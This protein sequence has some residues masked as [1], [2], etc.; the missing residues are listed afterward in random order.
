MNK[1]NLSKVKEVTKKVEKMA[2]KVIVRTL[3]D[4][5]R[6]YLNARVSN[7][8][9]DYIA[10]LL[11]KMQE[12]IRTNKPDENTYDV[13]QLIF[14]NLVGYDTT[15]ADFVVLDVMSVNDFSAKRIAYTAA[16]QM[17]NAKSD[18]VLMATQRIQRDLTTVNPLLTSIVLTSIP[19]YLS[20]PLA[21]HI[22]HD[23]ISLMTS[24]K[25]H[26]RQK[27]IMTFYHICL[28][29]PDALKAGFV[30]L[31]GRLDDTDNSVVF[32]SLSVVGELCAHNPQ[33]FVS[34]IPKL[35][36]MLDGSNSNWISLRLV[37]IL[38][39]LCAAEPRLPKKLINP[40]TQILETTSS[41]TLLFETVRAIIEIPITNTVLLTYAAQ[42][43]QSFLE[44]Q[45]TNLRYL[46]LTLFIKL[47][48]IQPKLVAQHKELISQ[49]LDS[50]DEPTRLMALDLLT[51]L[52]NAK[53]ID[54]I[55]AKCYEHYSKDSTESFKNQLITR[56][57]EI[58]SKNDYG[59]VQDFDWYITVLLDFIEKGGFTCY[60]I[61]ADQFLDLAYR[62]PATR[63]R[64]VVEMAKFF[65][66]PDLKEAVPLLL[67]ASHIVGDYA[68]DSEQFS[69]ILQ[70]MVINMNERVQASC[71]QTAFKLYLKCESQEQ[72][73]AVEGMFEL[74][75]PLLETSKYA[76]VQDIANLTLNVVHILRDSQDEEG[77]DEL[78]AFM[79]PP[80]DN[81][82]E[83]IEEII[84]PAELDEP[85]EIFQTTKEDHIRFDD[86]DDP[87]LQGVIDTIDEKPK[88]KVRGEKKEKKKMHKQ[89]SATEKPVILKTHEKI[90]KR[91]SLSN[92]NSLSSG[93]KPSAISNALATIDLSETVAEVEAKANAPLQPTNTSL[94]A[95]KK[96][97]EAA[98]RE[99]IAE[100]SAKKHIVKKKKRTPK[101]DAAPSEVLPKNASGPPVTGPEGEY[102][103]QIVGDANT[104]SI[105]GA[106]F[107]VQDSEPNNMT[108]DMTIENCTI[109]P[110]QSIGIELK[111]D[112]DIQA[113]DVQPVN[114][115]LEGNSKVSHKIVV[116]IQ[117][118][119]K[120]HLLKL[121]FVPTSGGIEPLD[122]SFKI[123]PSYF[124]LPATA[125]QLEDALGNCA[126][127]V[128][129]QFSSTT[130]PKVL[131]QCL[132]NVL[133]GSILPSAEKRERIVFSKAT[134]G[135]RAVGILIADKAGPQLR[136]KSDDQTL[137]ETLLREV[138]QA[139]QK[140]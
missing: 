64:L 66:S 37:N 117:N 96:A 120:P 47:M 81:E 42:R 88:K 130:S 93:P 57:V 67:A 71:I 7:T 24:A 109:L 46:C 32:S 60:D 41:I 74:K 29:F 35:A 48:Q 12:E 26:L 68:T 18:V 105:V 122:V 78:G 23:V 62:V 135:E 94:I 20:V 91:S 118:P 61:V 85:I 87:L 40:F 31:R 128:N 1:L 102:R 79:T 27:A 116:S 30:T 134:T 103:I 100:K 22:H 104:L 13:Q 73:S 83:E 14:L 98:K 16:S 95:K 97:A 55:V 63:E 107:I 113:V 127:E 56:V 52:A 119:L 6:Q 140:A 131:L 54:G 114:D 121:R 77:Y 39:I 10:D 137:A 53:T 51:N 11:A 59:L 72:R 50:D 101:Q 2:S 82:E 9:Q 58:C 4:V 110:V 89:N 126:C 65:E 99:M 80:D 33:N 19:P 3:A 43:M 5:I 75:L 84:R 133:H 125:E 111:P 108:V 129:N 17:W 86:V 76:E 36:K 115:Q 34:L 21:Q 136:I 8:E 15:W 49:C 123:F 132:V 138:K 28:Q 38:K 90:L 45:D 112:D 106:D 139:V 25:P 69:K 44:H 70:P 124:L 92:T